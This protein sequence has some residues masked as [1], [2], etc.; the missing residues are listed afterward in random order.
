MSAAEAEA[1]DEAGAS[2]AAAAWWFGPLSGAVAAFALVMALKLHLLPAMVAGLLVHELVQL[3]SG[4]FVERFRISRSGGKLAAVTVISVLVIAGLVVAGFGAVAFVRAQLADLD[5]LLGQLDGILSSARAALPAWIDAWLPSDPERLGHVLVEWLKEHAKEL[6]TVGREAAVGFVH[7]L[8]GMVIGALV[9][10]HE[11]AKAHELRPLAAALQERADRL[12]DSFRAIV[13]AQV[14]ISAFNT[15]LTAIFLG[16]VLPAFGVHMPLLQL[17]VVITFL[18]GLL[19]VLGNLVSNTVITVVALTQSL[20]LA[21][22]CLGY[23]V[24]IHKLEYFVNARLVGGQIHANA[25][26]LLIAML[27][28]ESAFGVPGVVAAPIYYAYLKQELR[29]IGWI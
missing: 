3:I 15:S 16:L 24:V 18:A 19:P 12:S 23:L 21:G 22:V 7:V 5:G 26:E 9:S 14:Q 11:A 17:L 4:S 25:W 2:E 1:M 10:L 13:F 8:I 20:T 29:A 27:V 6:Q 28:M